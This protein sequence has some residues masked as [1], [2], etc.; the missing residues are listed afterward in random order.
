MAVDH[1]QF[2]PWKSIHANSGKWYES[3]ELLG[4]GG[5]AATF[6]ARCTSSPE[7]GVLF[8]IKVF[9]KL[10]K[11]ERKDSFLAEA[12]FL[13]E[14]SHPAIMRV[15]D[16]G[17][18]YD[19]NPFIVVEYLPATLAHVIRTGAPIIEKISYSM[20]LL[21]AVEFLAVQTPPVAH[22]DIK[23]SNIFIK[24]ASC[25]L[26]D[27][28]LMKRLDSEDEQ[29]KQLVKASVG[30]GMPYNYRTPELVAYLNGTAP[31]T[32]KTDVFQLGLVLAQ[33]FTRRNPLK[34]SVEFTDPIELEPLGSIPSKLGGSIAALVNRMLILS[35][36]ERPS[37][38]EL[39]DGWQGLFRNAVD[40][41]HLLE[42]RAFRPR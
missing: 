25:V 24:G 11:P 42:D 30:L 37:A 39:L 9:R 10:S 5:N 41:A 26:G 8:A 14:S 3:I 32:T 23:P 35:A 18:Y 6:L 7:R 15:F 36:D 2:D 12:R 27:F 34:P 1:F 38:G 20:Q 4:V 16:E 31:L 13:R 40:Q 28:G 22:R 21:S 19:Q 29:D 17:T 33:L